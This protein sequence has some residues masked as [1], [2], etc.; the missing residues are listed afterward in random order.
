MARSNEGGVSVSTIAAVFRNGVFA[1]DGN[2]DL[3]DGVR[4]MLQVEVAPPA[5]PASRSRWMQT[6]P[7]EPWESEE[8]PAPCDL[9]MGHGVIVHARHVA[10]VLPD[11]P[12]CE[13]EAP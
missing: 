4:V 9:P 5:T 1:P 8:Q 11:P 6:L 12:I 10:T 13:T 2:V 3:T 7:D